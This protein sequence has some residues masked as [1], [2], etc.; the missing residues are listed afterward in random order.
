[1]TRE[2]PE[3]QGLFLQAYTVKDFIFFFLE[4]KNGLMD[5]LAI[6]DPKTSVDFSDLLLVS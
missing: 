1:M 4:K 3:N 5:F 6:N 2:R